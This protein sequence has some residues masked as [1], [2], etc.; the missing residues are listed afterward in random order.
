MSD[1][2]TTPVLAYHRVGVATGDHVPT[3]SPE[4]FEAQVRWMHRWG[5]QTITFSQFIAALEQDQPARQ[6]T[7]VITFDDG[8]AETYELAA[9]ILRRY[10]FCGIVFVTPS[11][12]GQQ[13]FL[14]WDQVRELS[15]DS[16][17]VGS[18]TMHHTYLPL[19]SREQVQHELTESKHALDQRL[20]QPVEWLSYPI[21]GF[22]I[23]IQSLAKAAGY[24]AACTT[25]RGYSKRARDLFAIRR[26]KVTER[27]QNPLLFWT[28]LSGYYD[29]FRR[30]ERPA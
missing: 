3:V 22:N 14:T 27:D 24:R 1:W 19:V 29:V 20:G 17:A 28:K 9:P 16:I 25:N 30:L 15:Q 21:G 2:W 11:E 4:A 12:V 23:E 6:R 7:V 26:I 8:Y 13:G 5:Y 18:H 10:G